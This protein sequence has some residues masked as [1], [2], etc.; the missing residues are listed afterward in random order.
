MVILAVGAA[1]SYA[2]F[3]QWGPLPSAAIGAAASILSIIISNFIQVD[4]QWYRAIILRLG[5]FHSLKGPGLFFGIPIVYAIPYWI[6]IRV[7]TKGFKAEKTHQ[8]YRP[9][10]CRAVLEGD[11]SQ[12]GGP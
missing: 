7:I 1:V 9:C 12:A 10:R 5:H 8:G 6:D 4:D 2:G 11:R 3:L